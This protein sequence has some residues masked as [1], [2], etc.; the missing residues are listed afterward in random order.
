MATIRGTITEDQIASSSKEGSGATLQTYA[1][2]SAGVAGNLPTFDLTGALVDS[3]LPGASSAVISLIL[4]NSVAVFG[5]LFEV[6]GVP[7]V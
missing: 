6:N 4:V 1:G 3:G 5:T 7:L 2:A